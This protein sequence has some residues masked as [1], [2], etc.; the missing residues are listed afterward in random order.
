[1]RKVL[2]FLCAVFAFQAAS[3]Q[4]GNL[5]RICKLPAT[6]KIDVSEFECIYDYWVQDTVLERWNKREMILLV[7]KKWNKYMNYN[8]FRLDSVISTKD[9]SKLT[10]GQYE[11]IKKEYDIEWG[12]D[13]TSFIL[14]NKTDGM[15]QVYDRVM[16]D[17]FVYSDSIPKWNWKLH[18]ETKKYCGYVCHKATTRFRGRNWVAWY[19]DLPVSEGPWKFSGLPGLILAVYDTST[20]QRF[21]ANTVR[22]KQ[23]A[24]VLVDRKEMKTTRER[25]NKA[26][27]EY[28]ENAGTMI[29]NSGLVQ[30]VTSTNGDIGPSYKRIFFNP[31]ELE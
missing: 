11:S 18:N 25:F 9:K 21:I 14:K 17:R 1:M 15:L 30:K 6:K 10:V 29:A 7:G 5:N 27:K 31:I 20:N 2:F 16:L 28:C 26:Q 4:N 22:K 8:Y 3:A 19:C 23:N 12:S 13:M 24:I